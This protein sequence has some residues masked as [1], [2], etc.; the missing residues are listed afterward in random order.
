MA[1]ARKKKGATPLPPP[2][3]PSETPPVMAISNVRMPIEAKGSAP[4]YY[5]NHAEIN[6]TPF[7][8]AITFAKLPPR[9]DDEENKRLANG[10]PVTIP[11]EVQILLPV[12][13]VSA[14]I[15]AIISIKADFDKAYAQKA[16]KTAEA[17]RDK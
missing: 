12:N 4:S 9:F 3:L 11:A 13:F 1:V 8:M 5:V 16:A 6:F 10:Q 15:D 7:E 14:L 2:E 17:T